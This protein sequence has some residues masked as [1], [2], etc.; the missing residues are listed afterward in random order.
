VLSSAGPFVPGDPATFTIIVTNQ[1]TMTA[2]DIGIADYPPTGLTLVPDANWSL[3]GGQISAT[4]PGPL[5]P[6]GS[7]TLPIT[8]TIDAGVAGTLTNWAEITGQNG[9]DG[10][11][12]D[13]DSTADGDDSNDEFGGDDVTDNSNGDE[14][15]H[16]PADL[17]V[18]EFMDLAL[19][20]VLSSTGPFLPGD[21]VTF[22]VMVTNQGTMTATDIGVAD[23]VPAGLSLQADAI[24][25][26]SGGQATTTIAGPLAPGGSTSLPISFTIDAGVSGVLIN[27]A[28]ITGQNGPDGPADDVDST[29]NNDQGDDPYGGDNI[30]DNSNGDEDD[31]DPAELPVGEFMDL[32]LIKVL[33][34]TGPFGEGDPVTFSIIVTNQGTMTASNIGIADY[35]PNGLTLV[36]D[37]NWS[38]VAGQIA[39]TIAGPLAPG[40]S[41]QLPITF[42]IDAGVSGTLINWAEISGQDGPDGPADDIDSTPNNDPDDDTFGGDDVTDNGNGDEDD[43]DPAELTVDPAPTFDLALVKTLAPG[44]AGTV[45]AGGT[46]TFR[47]TV[48][49]QGQ[50][51]AFNVELTDYIPAGLSLADANWTAG[52]NDT[53]TTVLAGPIAPG[54]QAFVDITLAVSSTLAGPVTNWAEISDDNSDTPDVDSTPDGENTDP[55]GEDNVTDNSNGDEDDHDPASITVVPPPA[56]DLALVKTLAIGQAANVTAGDTVTF[57]ITV[58]NQGQVP[59]TNVELTDYIPA[60]LSLVDP[61]WIAGAN[62]TATITVAGPITPGAQA[63]VDITLLVADSVSGEVINWAEIS[64]DN[65]DTGDVD[66]TPDGDNNDNFGG[67]DL[68][69]NSNGDEDDHDPA[70]ITVSQPVYDL[71]L[72]K[73]LAPGQSAEVAPGASVTYQITVY[74]QGSTP[75]S[76]ITIIDYMPASMTL[77][78]PSWIAGPGNTATITLN[79]SLPAGGVTTVDITVKLSDD[80]TTGDS[81]QNWAE[82]A[83]FG[84]GLADIDSTPNS[85]PDDDPF[86]QDNATDNQNGDEDDQDP[87]T[88]SVMELPVRVGDYVWYDLDA[89]GV[90]DTDETGVQGVRVLL[91]ETGTTISIGE[92]FTDADGRYLFD[93]L[94]PGDYQVRFDFSTLP[95]NYFVSPANQGDDAL[96]SDASVDSEGFS[97]PTGDLPGGSEDL[98]LDLGIYPSA[99]VGDTVWIDLN[100]DGNPNNEDLTEFGLEGITVNLY[101]DTG[102]LIAT[103]VTGTNGYYIFDGLPVGDYTVEVDVTTVPESLS[104]QTT[105]LSYTVNLGPGEHDELRDFGFAPEPTAIGLESFTA[106][107]TAEGVQLEWIT[108]WEDET[109]GFFVYVETADGELQ[110]VHDAI[111]LAQGGG[112]Y[113]LLDAGVV[114]GRYHLEEVTIHLETELQEEI[115]IPAVDASPEPGTTH[116]VEA[117]RFLTGAEDANYLVDDVAQNAR[118]LDVTDP[119]RPLQLEGEPLQAAEKRALYFRAAADRIIEISE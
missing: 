82:I 27:W 59:A 47:I 35:P 28:E 115:A 88:V 12:D 6:G 51:P 96:D 65:S 106:S 105:P 93:D 87:A 112:A 104:L 61:N 49:N 79:D 18:D 16:D 1:G 3:V 78:D 53:A 56:F 74:N 37:A 100:V 71:A 48:F 10:P 20:K 32:A 68:T 44:Q 116:M 9:P 13:I 117:A 26:L 91:F 29:P 34:S 72:I 92:T 99:S 63:S 114:G 76:P 86:G 69:D 19:T 95:E 58:F 94:P 97:G 33:S 109:L 50:L 40:Q 83:D 39:T 4:I 11:E 30:T 17:T 24:W 118:V 108:A 98:T 23:Y 38:L 101:D 2:S 55:F 73:E 36:A 80:L 14:D 21:P 64:D 107:Q 75:V 46:V 25:S 85:D 60:G 42:T 81:L 110:R 89:D 8:F 7:T 15:D 52:P 102:T 113:R 54:A 103:T 31:H 22:T 43:H 70:S 90:Q 67:D 62:N 111:V 45:T 84:D 41:T 5:A 77:A 66:S 57:T 119:V